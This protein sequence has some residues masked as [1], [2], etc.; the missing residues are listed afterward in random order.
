MTYLKSIKCPRIN[1]SKLLDGVDQISRSI[2][3]C[4]KLAE[5]TLGSSASRQN[6]E[7]LNP[8]KERSGDILLGIDRVDSKLADCIKIAEGTLQNTKQKPGGGICGGSGK[9]NPRLVRMGPSSSRIPQ[10]PSPKPA[11]IRTPK[12]SESPFDHDFDQFMNNLF[13][14]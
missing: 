14:P 2:M 11:H 13:A 7:V 12:P 8:P 10:N 1:N 4:I 3:G 9:T 5:S 6:P